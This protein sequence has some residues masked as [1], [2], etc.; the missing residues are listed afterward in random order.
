MTVTGRA[1]TDR[2]APPR[3]SVTGPDPVAP[4][5]TVSTDTDPIRTVSAAFDPGDS[6]AIVGLVSRNVRC[7]IG[8]DGIAAVTASF[9]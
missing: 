8:Y 5:E 6:P 9:A 4:E 1:G 3:G 7:V 2:A